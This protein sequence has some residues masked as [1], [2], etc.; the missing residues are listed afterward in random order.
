MT[1][2]ASVYP[3]IEVVVAK[4]LTKPY[5]AYFRGNAVKVAD[6]F[7]PIVAGNGLV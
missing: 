4:E 7:R 1:W 6:M 5:E 2:L 3:I